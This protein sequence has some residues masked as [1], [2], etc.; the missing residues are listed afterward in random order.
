M[1][2]TRTLKVRMAVQVRGKV[3]NPVFRA[4]QRDREMRPVTYPTT[5]WVETYLCEMET[6]RSKVEV[7]H[8]LM[9][10]GKEAIA[11]HQIVACEIHVE[12][13]EEPPKPPVNWA[14]QS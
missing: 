14:I 3:R 11:K 5:D 1:A 6:S 8:D 4:L 2:V 9:A 13:A 10:L 12:E 7:E